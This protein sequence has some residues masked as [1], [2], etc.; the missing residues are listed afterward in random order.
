MTAKTSKRRTYWLADSITPELRERGLLLNQKGY[1]VHFFTSLESFVTTLV[2]KRAGVIVVSDS[3]EEKLTEKILLTFMSLAEV[4][5]ARMVMVRSKIT[6]SINVLATCAN[7]RDIIPYDLDTK[8]FLTR[9]I[10]A[11]AGKPMP[12]IQ[13]TGQITLN[14]IAAVSLAARLTWISSKHLR[15][16]CRIRPPLGAALKL[17]GPLAAALGVPFISLEVIETQRSHMLYRFSDAAVARWHIGTNSEATIA[18]VFADLAKHDPGP[19]CRIFIAVP[20]PELRGQ[21][22]MHF[23]GPMFEIQTAMQKQ[24]IIDEPRFFTPDVVVIEDLLCLEEGGERFAAMMANLQEQTT[25]IIL[26]KIPDFTEVQNAWPQ[27][28]VIQFARLPATLAQQIIN[29]YIPLRQTVREAD[30]KSGANIAS[31]HRFS[32]AEIS[33]TARLQRIHPQATQLALPFPIGNFALCR[34]DSPLLRRM[35]GRHP[36]VKLTNTFQDTHPSA[37]PFINLV[38]GYLADL[39]PPEQTALGHGLIRM[40]STSLEKADLSNGFISSRI[41]G[42]EARLNPAKPAA[43]RPKPVD[44]SEALS[45]ALAESPM[46]ATD[47]LQASLN[48]QPEAR[49]TEA[50]EVFPTLQ[51]QELP[52]LKASKAEPSPASSAI[53]RI[54]A[55][56]K[57]KSFDYNTAVKAILI[58]LIAGGA[59]IGGFA[60][61]AGHVDKSGGKFSNQLEKFNNQK[62]TGRTSE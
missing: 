31:P 54:R 28:R 27:Q 50:L 42:G 58:I 1:D 8:S 23:D 48:A 55:R 13:P 56:R 45:A 57:A 30:D 14:D 33:F 60:M 11:T 38:E 9:F 35:I 17:K 3:F 49:Q 62:R 44:D 20:T 22:L 52:L 43:V 16:E 18:P 12:F 41:S 2:N 53:R 15:F 4:Q 6:E 26:G 21:V 59:L 47:L 32:R 46:D 7:F 5:G 25:V 19:R 10:Y 36:Y 40:V 37:P 39:H 34:I 61:L 24:S 51:P 29:R